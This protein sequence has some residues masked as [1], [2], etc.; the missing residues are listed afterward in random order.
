MIQF[1][2]AVEQL[3]QQEEGVLDLLS[4]AWF[5]VRGVAAGHWNRMLVR[6]VQIRDYLDAKGRFK[7]LALRSGQG[8]LGWAIA[9]MPQAD[10]V[11]FFF[12]VRGRTLPPESAVRGVYGRT[13]RP[14]PDGEGWIAAEIA[15]PESIPS[16]FL[17][18]SVRKRVGL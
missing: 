4:Q 11:R 2:A 18:A 7:R 1:S 17:P 8:D 15:D 5:W 12:V 13:A 14:T 3:A 10:E 9:V 6:P 16:K